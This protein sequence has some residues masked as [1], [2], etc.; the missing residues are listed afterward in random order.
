MGDGRLCGGEG[1]I[2][3]GSDD[4]DDNFLSALRLSFSESKCWGGF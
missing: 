2:D 4:D 3:A 1:E